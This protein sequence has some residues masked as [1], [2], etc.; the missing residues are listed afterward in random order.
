MPSYLTLHTI[1]IMIAF[2]AAPFFGCY[3]LL[4]AIFEQNLRPVTAFL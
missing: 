2:V 4:L 3:E 1:G